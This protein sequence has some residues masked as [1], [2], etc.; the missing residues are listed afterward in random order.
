MPEQSI[1]EGTGP[2]S[3]QVDAPDGAPCYLGITLK[4]VQVGPSP[5][6]M[7]R[8]LRTIGIEPKN[9]VVDITN[10]VLHDLGQP[11]HAFDADRIGG[12]TV[13]VRRAKDEEAF[14]ALDGREM[15]LTSSDLVIAD[16]QQAMCL[17]GVF[18]GQNSGVGEHTTRVFLESAWN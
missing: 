11:L 6:W 13:R 14:T 16:D 3:L 1:K 18:G 2:I 10:Y 15:S 17:A 5:D 4:N 7:Q 9:N 8:R 12:G